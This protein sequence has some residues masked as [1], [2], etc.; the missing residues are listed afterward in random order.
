[1]VDDSL[2]HTISL[3]SIAIYENLKIYGNLYLVG[4]DPVWTYRNKGQNP[5]FFTNP[6]NE[7]L[8]TN[9]VMVDANT[10]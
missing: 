8:R 4:I 5:N 3:L 10:K 7:I 6:N 1:M 2:E 9:L